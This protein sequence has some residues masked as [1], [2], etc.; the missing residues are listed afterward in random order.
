MHFF[1]S[2]YIYGGTFIL[3]SYHKG[4]EE[5]GRGAEMPNVMDV[6]DTRSTGLLS[7]KVT[8]SS[9]FIPEYGR[10]QKEVDSRCTE[11]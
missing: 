10:S 3:F 8:H 5:P 2:L 4:K 7:I 11:D 9:H 6:V 1:L